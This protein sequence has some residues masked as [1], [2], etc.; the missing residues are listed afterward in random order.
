LLQRGDIDRHLRRTRRHY[1]ARRTA[2]A[3]AL[4][5]SLPEATVGGASA[6]LH[7]IAWLTEGTDETAI[8]DAAARRGVAIHALHQDCALT[9]PLPPALLLGY[10]LIG[11]QAIPRAVR[12]L[13]AAAHGE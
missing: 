6:G 5:D 12:E 7:L 3:A 1:N 13:A 9:A 10:G 4:A 2:L 8:V 11:E